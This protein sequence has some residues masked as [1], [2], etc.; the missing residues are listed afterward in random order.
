VTEA[1]SKLDLHGASAQD[2]HVWIHRKGAAP[3]YDPDTQIPLNLLPLPGSR[4][5]PTL[6]LKPTFSASTGWGLK[7][8]LSLAHGA[9][10]AISRAKAL[11]AL[12]SKY[13]GLNILEPRAGDMQGTWVIC[14]E[15]DLVWEEAPEAYK[16]V[17][18]VGQDLVD[19]G[20][21]EIVG[22]CRARVSYKVR[23]E[24]R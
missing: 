12:A 9:G 23:N 4:G 11:S 14:D 13:K 15:K 24:A 2:H 17:E 16:D 10:R 7:N 1:A 20:V 21:A 18:L 22:R 3:T 19:A 6:I 8:A 5:T